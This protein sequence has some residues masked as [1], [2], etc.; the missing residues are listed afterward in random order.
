MFVVNSPDFQQRQQM[1][2]KLVLGNEE[3]NTASV[4]MEIHVFKTFHG[5][6]ESPL[7]KMIDH[8]IRPKTNGKKGFECLMLLEFCPGGSVID[9]LKEYKE[10][11]RSSLSERQI[12]A[13]LYDVTDAI[14]LLH[15]AKPQAI[16]HRDIK[17]ENILI[18]R[19]GRYKLCDFG[20][21]TTDSWKNL[22]SRE[23][24]L[25]QIEI[26]KT[27]TLIYRAPE[28]CDLYRGFPV[29]TKVDIWALGIV[30]FLLMFQRYPFDSQLAILNGSINIPESSPYSKE[31]HGLLCKLNGR[32]EIEIIVLY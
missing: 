31:L 14:A 28:M 13:I 8:T 26:E 22:S 19:D 11:K 6:K 29:T 7:I 30:T 21:C 23:V 27:T 16:I 25:K 18:A 5:L 20:S 12:L 3:G 17:P 9:M 2:L 4:D 1:V 32:I 15:G 10:I 24:P